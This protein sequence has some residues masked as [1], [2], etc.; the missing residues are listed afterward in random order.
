MTMH[1][2]RDPQTRC[3][4]SS[5]FPSSDKRS[6]PFLVPAALKIQKHERVR[7]TASVA[8]QHVGA[9]RPH[10]AVTTHV[11]ADVPCQ[12]SGSQ[13]LWAAQR[14]AQGKLH[15]LVGNQ[16]HQVLHGR[17]SSE[18]RQ[19]TGRRDRASL[20]S[21]AAGQ[22]AGRRQRC[23]SRPCCPWQNKGSARGRACSAQPGC[24]WR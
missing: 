8:C 14:T 18:C 24:A 15:V 3:S 21:I 22:D 9:T 23:P 20:V 4:C 5:S 2:A 19:Q 16:H 11:R 12:R 6:F 17:L 1:L 10:T 7:K 13:G